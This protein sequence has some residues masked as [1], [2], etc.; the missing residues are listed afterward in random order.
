M[1]KGSIAV[2]WVGLCSPKIH[3]LGFSQCDLIKR[4]IADVIKRSLSWSTEGPSPV[5][6][7]SLLWKDKYGHRNV[8]IQGLHHVKTGATLPQGK[9]PPRSQETGPERSLPGAFRGSMALQTPCSQTCSLHNCETIIFVY[10]FK[11]LSL[12]YCVMAALGN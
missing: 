5:A 11:L 1:S 9:K 7:V 8:H 10:L 12:C 2:L 4:A 3:V 6:L